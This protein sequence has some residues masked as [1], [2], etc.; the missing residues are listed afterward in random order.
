[1][2]VG[3]Y[4]PRGIGMDWG[5][6]DCGVMDGPCGVGF[7]LDGGDGWGDPDIRYRGDAGG[8]FLDA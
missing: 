8:E 3:H 1:M 5:L 6:I 7:E 2:D 4:V